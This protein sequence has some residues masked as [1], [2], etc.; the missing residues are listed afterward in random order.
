MQAFSESRA[1]VR[2]PSLE[3]MY[4]A[5]ERN[6]GRRKKVGAIAASGMAMTGGF[7][8]PSMHH[9]SWFKVDRWF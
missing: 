8:L 1:L 6:S 2:C 5:S 9:A 7:T 4:V 3:C